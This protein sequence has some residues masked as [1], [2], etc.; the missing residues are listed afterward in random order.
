VI[1]EVPGV[2]PVIRC[3]RCGHQVARRVT[4][5]GTRAPAGWLTLTGPAGSQHRC[6]TCRQGR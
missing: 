1:V 5:T 6:P 4:P 3:D 2:G